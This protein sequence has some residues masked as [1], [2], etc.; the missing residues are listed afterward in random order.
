[1]IGYVAAKGF[2]VVLKSTPC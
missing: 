1:M 2:R